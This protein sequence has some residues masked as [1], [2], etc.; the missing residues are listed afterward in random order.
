MSPKTRTRA[1]A[2]AGKPTDALASNRVN[3]AATQ[4]WMPRRI[5]T[6]RSAFESM[7]AMD[8]ELAALAA[9]AEEL[10][11]SA[12]IADLSIEAYGSQ[13]RMFCTWASRYGLEPMPAAE[14]TILLYVAQLSIAGT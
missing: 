10:S 6:P 8:P 14:T 4:D 1:A 11:S 9:I 3:A 7:G 5:D 12:T 13:W 2:A